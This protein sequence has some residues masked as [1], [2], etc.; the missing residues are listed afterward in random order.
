MKFAGRREGCWAGKNKVYLSIPDQPTSFS[1][2]VKG[3]GVS[4]AGPVFPAEV[5]FVTA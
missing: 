3:S 2:L 4:N 5:S 1:F